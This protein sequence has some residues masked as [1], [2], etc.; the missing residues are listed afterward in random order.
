V[1]PDEGGVD[2]LSNPDRAKIEIKK[3]PV[4]RALA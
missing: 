4:Q 1:N 3:Q 2:P